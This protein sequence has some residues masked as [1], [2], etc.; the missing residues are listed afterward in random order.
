MIEYLY[1][2]FNLFMRQNTSKEI[3]NFN[4]HTLISTLSLED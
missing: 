4:Y 2:L 1:Y 3:E